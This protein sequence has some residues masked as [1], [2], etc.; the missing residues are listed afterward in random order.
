M[1]PGEWG[2]VTVCWIVILVM[3]LGVWNHYRKEDR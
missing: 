1:T 3:L 2:K